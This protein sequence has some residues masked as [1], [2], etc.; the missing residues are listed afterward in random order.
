V[1]QIAQSLDARSAGLRRFLPE[2]R[3][4]RIP[5]FGPFRRSQPLQIVDSPRVEDDRVAHARQ[6]ILA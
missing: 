3:L 2:V 1:T 5:D 6:P 4:D